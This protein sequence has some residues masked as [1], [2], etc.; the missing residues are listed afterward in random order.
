MLPLQRSRA[1]QS[2]YSW[3]SDSNPG[4]AAFPIHTLAK[5]LSKFLHHRAVS[6]IIAKSRSGPLSKG[7]LEVLTWYLQSRDKD[8]GPSTKVLILQELNRR[9][10]WE[11][12]THFMVEEN[13][14]HAIVPLLG[15]ANDNLLAWA[16]TLLGTLAQWRSGNAAIVDV[17]PCHHFVWLITYNDSPVVH[18]QAVYALT[19]VGQYSAAGA[20]DSDI[21]EWT[22]RMAVDISHSGEILN[23]MSEVHSQ[24]TTRRITTNNHSSSSRDRARLNPA[25]DSTYHYCPEIQECGSMPP[26]PMTMGPPLAAQVIHREDIIEPFTL[27]PM[28]ESTLRTASKL[29]DSSA[30]ALVQDHNA[31]ESREHA[32]FNPPAYSPYPSPASSPQP[33]DPIPL[34]QS[35]TRGEFLPGHRTCHE[36]ASVDT[37]Q[38]YGSNTSHGGG[39]IVLAIDEVIGRM[40]LTMAPESVIGSAMTASAGQSAGANIISRLTH[41]DTEPVIQERYAPE[42]QSSKH[43]RLDPCLSTNPDFEDGVDSNTYIPDVREPKSDSITPSPEIIHSERKASRIE[44]IGD[45]CSDGSVIP[46][47]TQSKK[48]RAVDEVVEMAPADHKLILMI[49]CAEQGTRRQRLTH[50]TTFSEVLDIIHETI[51]CADVDE[52]PALMYKLSTAGKQDEAIRLDSDADWAGCREEVKDAEKDKKKAISVKIIVTDQYLYS[53]RVKLGVKATDPKVNEKQKMQILALDHAQSGDDDFN[54]GLNI[55]EKEKRYL[56]QLES[57]YGKCQLCGPTKICKTTITGAHYHL[58]NNQLRNWSHSLAVGTHAVTLETPP[59]DTIFSMFFENSKAAPVDPASTPP[60]S[61]AQQMTMNPIN[62]FGLMPWAMPTMLPSFHGNPTTSIMPTPAPLA[63]WAASSDP[64]STFPSSDT[65][66]MAAGNPYP[67]ISYFLSKLNELQPRRQLLRSI[68]KFEELDFYNI[69]ELVELGP[70]AALAQITSISLG[71]ATYILEKAR[72]EIKRIDREIK[73]K[74]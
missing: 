18:K 34:P 59:N 66:N 22:S 9:A 47:K 45:S 71:N 51:G 27:R 41:N 7:N 73:L 16:C 12:Q 26:P 46:K 42:I 52:K 65:P 67:E 38:S 55:M 44:V 3:W 23:N 24:R 31:A 56:E 60:I 5:P 43:V 68:P 14:Q 19:R 36:K 58:S 20:Q 49:P 39:E 62:P 2:I 54:D 63:S 35:P 11:A 21:L 37:Q 33:T 53:L 69:D 70:A 15:S 61:M 32:R 8:I 57:Q 48:A 25:V 17:N 72:A 4:G 50:A 10:L 74:A 64:S 13:V 6:S 29:Q 40:G 28:S 1:P 30:A